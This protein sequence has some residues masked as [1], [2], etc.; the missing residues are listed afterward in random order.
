MN[1]KLTYK[2]EDLEF[3]VRVMSTLMKNDIKTVGDLVQKTR[4]E[5]IRIPNFGIKSL[6]EIKE[7]LSNMSLELG[8]N[9]DTQPQE[10][11]P[12]VF[13]NL[14]R[15][16]LRSTMDAFTKTYNGIMDLNKNDTVRY[17]D[18]T[19]AFEQHKKV[20]DTFEESYRNIFN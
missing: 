11:Q 14:N 9:I 2:I 18:M 6:N 19:Q 10:P 15:E 16:I 13:D 8:M 3:S 5:L 1:K 12:T 7:V 4:D 20:L 17:G